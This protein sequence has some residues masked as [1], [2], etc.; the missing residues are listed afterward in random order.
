[1]NLAGQSEKAQSL[2]DGIQQ[3]RYKDG[4]QQSVSE[5]KPPSSVLGNIISTNPKLMD[6]VLSVV[7]WV[8]NTLGLRQDSYDLIVESLAGINSTPYRILYTMIKRGDPTGVIPGG[9]VIGQKKYIQD[10]HTSFYSDLVQAGF[11]FE[12]VGNVDK[13][14]NER[15]TV[16]GDST[17][18]L[19]R[20]E[21]MAFYRHTLNADNLRAI[22]ESG[23]GFKRPPESS[24]IKPNTVIPVTEKDVRAIVD[25]LSP[26]ERL[27]AGVP[28][29]NLFTG[30]GRALDDAFYANNKYRTE[31]VDNY[32]PKEVM[33]LTRG[34]FDLET[35]E[36]LE[37][38]RSFTARVGIDKGMLV[39]RV[40]STR[41]IYLGDL[42]GD[43]TRSVNRAGAYIHL[44]GP[45]RNASHLLYGPDTSFRKA[46]VDNYGREVWVELEKGLKDIA[47]NYRQW[48][49]T[50]TG[51]MK[52]KTNAVAGIISLNPWIWL[53]QP[54]SLVFYNTYVPMK[55]L[56]KG[57]VDC[58]TP[59][60]AAQVLD[61]ARKYSPEL[62]DRLQTGYDRDV[63]A[64][65]QQS[66]EREF[67][68]GG[69]TTVEKGIMPTK[70]ADLTAVLPGMRASYYAAM[71][72]FQ[73]K[74]MSKPIRDALNITDPNVVDTWSPEM[75][76][77]K[78]WEFA[79]WTTERT[80]AQ[81]GQEHRNPLSRGSTLE[82]V[83]TSLSS[84]VSTM[85]NLVRRTQR[86]YARTGNPEDR[87]A[88]LKAY[89]QVFVVNAAA[90]MGIDKVRD[91]FYG[92]ESKSIVQGFIDNAAGM[93]M[94]VRELESAVSSHVFEGQRGFD[95]KL[96]VQNF[97]EVLVRMADN[98]NKM[99][100]SKNQKDI[101]EAQA[102]FIDNTIALLATLKGLPYQTPK[103]VLQ[104]VTG[105]NPPPKRRN[106]P[107]FIDELID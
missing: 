77:Q 74:E 31:M 47:G 42:M 104:A 85:L 61:L 29:D 15:V 91:A 24:G 37:A 100:M 88:M 58:S 48:S 16:K 10:A 67:Y 69:H 80:Q 21:R 22:L 36:G 41:P 89:F 11:P 57:L 17:W 79:D 4:M 86:E 46:I 30:Q 5:L 18:I 90:M 83:F 81:S 75:L 49:E 59:S 35:E 50:E 99:V 84:Q 1:M 45:M 71:D 87:S 34:G 2:W 51:L 12:K 9:G 65:Y 56:A 13:W 53:N 98:V 70:W 14:L 96:P 101:G 64:A 19:S 54:A 73:T 60:G 62:V 32:Y 97:G 105:N 52:L 44:E 76:E 23:I 20:G 7:W 26:E 43:I 27:M 55:Y 6:R 72:A 82:Q 103:R 40:G 28:V 63:A 38:F 25:S 39:E 92:R 66:R 78:A 94:F 106:N 3:R 33:P 95:T 68:G 102:A 8:K 107:D 93:V